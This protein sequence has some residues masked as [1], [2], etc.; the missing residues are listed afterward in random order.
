MA[1]A[2]DLERN[3]PA[4]QRRLEQ[5]REQGQ[6][7]RSRELTAAA[8]VVAAVIGVG[9]L[10]PGIFRRCL[11]LVREGLHF[12]RDLAMSSDATTRLLGSAATDALWIASPLLLL[13]AAAGLVAPSLLSGWV[14]TT[15]GLLPDFG[16]LNPGKGLRNLISMHALS[17]LAKALLKSALLTGIG[18]LAIVQAWPSLAAAAQLDIRA[19][20]AVTGSI[21]MTTA[22][23]LV[24]GMVVIAAFD[25]PY[26]LWRHY[27]GLRMTREEL[28][29]EQK[30]QD[31]DP[32]LK[33][34]IRSLQRQGAR[35]R[36]MAAVPKASVI[37]TNPTHYAVALEYRPGMRAPRVVA[38][39][40]E[41]IA[42]RI[43]EIGV[44][45]HVPVIEAPPLARALYRHADLGQEVPQALY[46]VV[47]QVLA[48][49]Y[50]VQSSQRDSGGRV[51]VQPDFS[52]PPEFDPLAASAARGHGPG[53]D[54]PATG[55]R[56]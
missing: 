37:V 48:Y 4:S 45:H 1:E 41:L 30:E 8:V 17:E 39:G 44:A 14:F 43:R 15:K 35:R 12:D 29:Q 53:A 42:R 33:A 5:A 21:L 52:V 20:I 51:P 7:A 23:M 31:G 16:R 26:Q 32:H 18:A 46:I 56:A 6:V 40:T 9:A 49:V 50:Q 11:G 10:G 28:R 19:G 54:N 22:F 3:L 24:G 27:R 55:D 25:V 38:K 13:A 34:R 2:S 47:A 36:M